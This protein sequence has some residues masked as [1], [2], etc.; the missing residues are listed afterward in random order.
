[1]EKGFSDSVPFLQSG[2]GEKCPTRMRPT[3]TD[4]THRCYANIYIYI[5]IYIY[6]KQGE[7]RE[8]SLRRFEV[9]GSQMFIVPRSLS[10]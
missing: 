6:I 1:M 5:Y 7:V 9:N 3:G 10:P 8:I 2:G 4:K